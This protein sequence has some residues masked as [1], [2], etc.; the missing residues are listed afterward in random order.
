MVGKLARINV[1]SLRHRGGCRSP[2]PPP[3]LPASLLLLLLLLFVGACGGL[4]VQADRASS[5]YHAAKGTTAIKMAASRMLG[6]RHLESNLDRHHCRRALL[7]C[8]LRGGQG[9]EE[10]EGEGK[11]EGGQGGAEKGE[12]VGGGAIEEREDADEAS[13]EH[14]HGEEDGDICEDDVVM[15]SRVQ[16]FMA[17][18]PEGFGIG[19]E[20]HMPM[21]RL[22]SRLQA[23][24]RVV[25]AFN[26]RRAPLPSAT[27]FL[28]G[29][30]SVSEEFGPLP[31]LPGGHSAALAEGR[32]AATTAITWGGLA[33]S[34]SSTRAGAMASLRQGLGSAYGLSELEQKRMAKHEAARNALLGDAFQVGSNL[35]NV[36]SPN[37]LDLNLIPRHAQRGSVFFYMGGQGGMRLRVVAEWI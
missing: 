23:R 30:E 20:M 18:H 13:V 36:S 8:R 27:D 34:S 1:R 12:G 5:R 33:L 25:R 26:R 19:K 15:L 14:D 22:V 21:A 2:P 31:Q 3:S 7:A 9:G 24:S 17:A 16:A 6:H 28:R 37:A 35:L 11:G 10:G 29:V 32:A 4:D